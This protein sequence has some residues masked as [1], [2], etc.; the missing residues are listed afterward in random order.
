MAPFGSHCGVW[1]CG[2]RS[3]FS[4]GRYRTTRCVADVR[5]DRGDDG[6]CD[7]PRLHQKRQLL[8]LDAAAFKDVGASGNV[9]FLIRHGRDCQPSAP[10]APVWGS[11]DTPLHGG[12][13]LPLAECHLARLASAYSGI[14]SGKAVSASRAI[15]RLL[16]TCGNRAVLTLPHTSTWGGG[17]RRQPFSC[18]ACP[19]A[20]A[21]NQWPWPARSDGWRNSEP[22][23]G[24]RA[25]SP[26]L[27]GTG[28]GSCRTSAGAV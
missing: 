13:S 17:V 15:P 9:D 1:Q 24:S 18:S 19:C 7:R 27:R 4:G 25:A 11:D 22:P 20:L 8:T 21:P 6:L 26:I 28:R 3:R 5:S 14:S 12:P 23:S 16:L 10:P 2:H